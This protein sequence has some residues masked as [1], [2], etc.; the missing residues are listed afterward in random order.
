MET[1][2]HRGSFSISWCIPKYNLLYT[3]LYLQM[4]IAISHWSGSR[5]LASATP[6]ILNSHQDSFQLPV[7]ALCHENYAALDR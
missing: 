5:P 1:Y 4:F 2:S 3:H 6:S 7:D